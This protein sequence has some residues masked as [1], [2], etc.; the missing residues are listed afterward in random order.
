MYAPNLPL[1]QIIIWARAG[2]VN[3]APTH[4]VPTH[5]W[6]MIYAKDAWRLKSKAAS[7]VSDV[8][9]IPQDSDNPHPAPFPI[10]L[11]ARAI[12]TTAPRL[13]LDPFAGSG[14]TLRAAKSAGV[15]SIGIEI[16][17]AYCEMAAKR[18]SQKAFD[19]GE[20]GSD[21][22]AGAPAAPSGP[23]AAEHVH[24]WRFDGDDPYI[25]CACGRMQDALTGRVIREGAPDV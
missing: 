10:G 17:E 11:P 12:E 13:V 1:R 14:T 3:F 2:G 22:S 23:P 9:R 18:L 5:E 25:L 16:S 20:D 19:F 6:I 4:Y 8:W 15:R 24:R 7:G 21:V